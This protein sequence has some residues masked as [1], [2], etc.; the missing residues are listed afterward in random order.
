[1]AQLV[2]FDTECAGLVRQGKNKTGHLSKFNPKN[3]ASKKITFKGHFLTY[4]KVTDKLRKRVFAT[5]LEM[6]VKLLSTVFVFCFFKSLV[7]ALNSQV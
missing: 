3:K 4:S 5:D 1:M 6:I 7:F 2:Q